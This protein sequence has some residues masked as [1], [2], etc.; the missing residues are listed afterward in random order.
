MR[1]RGICT[2]VRAGW[3]ALLTSVVAASGCG[4]KGFG[5]QV[6]GSVNVDGKPAAGVMVMFCPVGGS[7]EVQKLRPQ[8]FTGPEGKFQLMSR[9]RGDGAPPG[10][11]KVLLQ[12]PAIEK[13]VVGD[14]GQGLGPDRL[15]GRYWNLE[16][17]QFTVQV[18]PGT[19]D[20]PPFELKTK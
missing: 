3:C 17:T 20:L 11:Y 2:L 1:R 12:W 14:G 6:N 15:Q 10:E 5:S 4:E 16:K 13:G 19:N 8:A 18:K 9:R 7:E